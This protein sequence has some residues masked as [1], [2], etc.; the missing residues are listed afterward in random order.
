M[1]FHPVRASE[2]ITE[3]Y[4]RYLKTI[5]SIDDEDYQR[6]FEK[7][8][9]DRRQ[10]SNG[11]YL[12]VTDSFVKGKSVN[13]LILEGIVPKSFDK[14]SFPLDRTLYLH[15]ETAIRQSLSGRNVVV[16]TG[17]GS[18]KT[19]SFLIP[20]LTELFREVEKRTISTPG[21]RALII[22][23]MNALANDQIE[24]LRGLLKDCPEITFGSYTGQTRQR[25]NDALEEYLSLNEGRRPCQNELISREQMQ[26]APP[27]IM[28][29]NYAMLE[30]LM[31]RP[32]DSVFFSQENT[33]NWRYIILDEA[34]VYSG[35]TG[36]EVS[37]LLRRL[38]ATLQKD[39]IRYILT[40]AT[41]GGD[42]SNKQVANFATELCS[43]PFYPE[44]VVRAV[45]EDPIAGESRYSL[46]KSFYVE[47][48]EALKDERYIEGDLNDILTRYAG[49]NTVNE[50]D[51]A[52]LFDI[53]RY[54]S[55][56]KAIKKYMSEPRR[57]TGLSS[58]LGWTD[59]EVEDFVT[60]ASK[61]EKGGTRLFDARYHIFLR[62]TESVFITLGD[63]KKLFL[64][65]KEYDED[66]VSGHRKKVF[67]IATCSF[68]HA[69]YLV[70]R[71]VNNTL[72]QSSRTIEEG[73][74][75]F[76]LRDKFSDSDEDHLMEDEALGAVEY[77]LCP[78][79]GFIQDKSVVHKR[80]CEHSRSEYV[81]VWKVRRSGENL[82]KCLACESV[83]SSGVTRMFF[84]GQEA[85]TS[86]IGTALFESLPSY[87]LSVIHSEETDDSGFGFGDEED[88]VIRTKEAKQFLAF[89]DSRQAAAFYA[90]Y[91]DRTYK[92]ILYKRIILDT[93]EGLGGHATF[94]G[95]VS[96]LEG[97][98]R[99]Y[100]I[101]GQNEDPRREAY[102]AILSELVDNNG[103]TSL[104]RMGMLSI[105]LSR[106]PLQKNDAYGLS[107]EEVETICN[108]FVLNMMADAAFTCDLSLSGEELEYITYSGHTSSY[109]E[110]DSDPKRGRKAFKPS[111]EGLSNKR[112]DYISK[113]VTARENGNNSDPLK[114]LTGLWRA[115]LTASGGPLQ[116]EGGSYRVD[117][118]K[119]DLE[120]GKQW[121]YCPKCRKLTC[122]NVRNVCPT[123]KCDGVL[124]PV[125]I[126]ELLSGNHYYELYKE[127]EIRPLRIKEHTAQLAR[128]TAYEY[129]KEFVN[130][131]IDVLSCST[132]FEMG[133]DV[134]SLETVFMR[135]MP[136]SPSNYAQRA[137]RAGRSI[138]SAA[139]ALTF[140]NKSNHDFTFFREPVRMIKGKIMPPSFNVEN[141]KIAVRHIYA[142]AFA[143]FW[144]NN[145]ES[146]RTVMALV[147][148][149]A[150]DSGSIDR[151]K[152]YLASK[153]EDLKEF[154]KRFLPPVLADHF[155]VDEFGWVNSLINDNPENKGVLS[156]A[157]DEYLNDVSSLIKERERLKNELKGDSYIVQRLKTYYNEQ[158]IAFLSRKGAFPRYGFPVDTVELEIPSQT[159][160]RGSGAASATKGL[161]LSRDLSMAISEYAPDSQIVANGELITSRYIKKAPNMLWKMYDYKKCLK[162]NSV[163]LVVSTEHNDDELEVCPVCGERL[164]GLKNTFIVPEFGFEADPTKITKPTLVKPNR[165]YTS[166]SSYIG[167]EEGQ[168]VEYIIGSSR[169]RIKHSQ[170]DEM[171]VINTTGYYICHACGYAEKD[172]E[173]NPARYQIK[174]GHNTPSGHKCGNDTLKRYSLGYRFQ[175]NVLHIRFDSPSLPAYKWDY[176][177][178]VLQGLIRGMCRYFSID[179]RDISGCLQ[180]YKDESTGDGRYAVILYDNT[181]GGSGFVRM[182]DGKESLEGILV[183]TLNTMKAC[184]CG[185]EAGDSS[186]Y[187]CLRNYYN[188]RYHEQMKRGYVIEFLQELMG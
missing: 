109:T 45:R 14:V 182:L 140:C 168:F 25:Y 105:D 132:T 93:I 8:L 129:Q 174:R 78:Y 54:D 13:D 133:V 1:A 119:L 15:Q 102:K 47:A 99:S 41:L 3:K 101:C 185:D 113:I 176:A 36:I 48:G 21:V 106:I 94:S 59:D 146:F 130:K 76:L 6:Q 61:A 160:R 43:S 19:E 55:T 10:F 125:D 162:C 123:Y 22:Y 56:F 40:S 134:G 115:I 143:F 42:D 9:N 169:I 67:E 108:E 151:F 161:Q 103:S 18:G 11:P 80:N 52:R 5:F 144:K 159:D 89:S 121:Y 75:L 173:G 39:D 180:Y 107:R 33:R 153:P 95:L 92:G 111:R 112:V 120:T 60:V 145:R 136:P 70:G 7:L 63:N 37:M 172:S 114:F 73:A 181:P 12:D 126:D 91:M 28:I 157:V 85:V 122:N 187:S 65:R 152:E 142:S 71:I 27:H 178:S 141:E 87:R 177:Y 68:C 79:C 154:L 38:K 138:D 131:E 110:A 117:V 104:F 62:A 30:Y 34:H 150:G 84:T 88:E 77:E 127:L 170:K 26:A 51:R 44:D 82:T 69:I 167:K 53:L 128:E 175:T 148:D 86:V 184:T 83:K 74:D 66:I 81:T 35:A 135:N 24:R 17:T 100:E 98:M 118:N 4:I 188:Q 158:S 186:C 179:D 2:E 166:E 149:G 163:S 116:N 72:V 96:Q 23:P 90:S 124:V 31:V 164:T 155:R 16:S 57:I 58:H 20:V 32:D 137:G 97:K 147:G 165:V 49:L 29:T 183:E 50:D 171:A 139:F 156:I 64:D 46:P